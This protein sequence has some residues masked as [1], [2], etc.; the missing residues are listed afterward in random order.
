[1][2]AEQVRLVRKFNRTMTHR[3]GALNDSFLNRGRPLGEARLLYEIGAPGAD[4]RELRS[5]LELDSGY[6]SRLV[7]SLERQGLVTARPGKNDARVRRL[8]LTRAGMQELRQLV[9]LSEEFAESILTALTPAQQNHLVNCMIEVERLMSASAIQITFEPPDTEDARWCFENYFR[10]LGDRFGVGFDTDQTISAMSE[11]LTPPNGT[12]AMARLD[13]RPVGCGALSIK[14]SRIGEIKR[15]WVAPEVRGL[16]V[17]KRILTMLEEFGRDFSLTVL[18][19]EANR[20]LGEA[21][22]LY[23]SSGYT[24]TEPFNPRPFVHHWFEKKLK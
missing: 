21:Q 10:D 19:I 3:L 22:S 20:I 5:R 18:R 14:E 17:G 12:F 4:L 2:D 15:M 11:L 23:R 13:G 16:G 8:T 24:E 6:V 1:M 7:R 9:R